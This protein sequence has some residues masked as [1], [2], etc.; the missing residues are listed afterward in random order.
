MIATFCFTNFL[1]DRC[2]DRIL[3]IFKQLLLIPNRIRKYSDLRKN[4]PT[5]CLINSTE[6]FSISSDLCISSIS[7]AISISR[8]HMTFSNIYYKTYIK[9]ILQSVLLNIICDLKRHIIYR[10][11]LKIKSNTQ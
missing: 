11:K 1:R 3:P 4:Y 9:L 6:F 5:P 2:N 8:A 10:L 7:I